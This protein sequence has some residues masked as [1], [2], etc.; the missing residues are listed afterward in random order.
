MAA[1]HWRRAAV[2]SPA[3]D[4]TTWI[5]QFARVLGTE[6]PSEDDKSTLLSL[7][8]VAANASERL[9]APICCWLVARAGVDPGDALAAARDLAARVPGT[10]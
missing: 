6:A 2:A 8:S 7:A 4:A 3:V 10:S 9:A 5:E 1:L